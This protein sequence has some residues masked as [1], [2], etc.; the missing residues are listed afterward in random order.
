VVRVLGVERYKGKARVSFSAGQ[1]ALGELAEEARLLRGLGR[2]LTCGPGEVR[3]GIDKIRRELAEAREALGRA[4]LRVAEAIADELIARA[5]A[6][7]GDAGG[8]LLV[9][10]LVD[11]ATIE[12]LRKVAQR[13]TARAG[14]VAL[15]AGRSPEG[16]LV[17]AARGSGS[18]FPCGAFLKRAVTVAGGRGGGRPEAAEGRMPAGADWETAVAAALADTAR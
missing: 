14:A 7:R 15:I 10:G 3:A 17:L 18:A 2:E 12:L 8:D 16:V 11:D 1:R 5:E 9:I 6:R 13:V 4:Q